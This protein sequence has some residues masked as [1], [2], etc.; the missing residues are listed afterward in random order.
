MKKLMYCRSLKDTSRAHICLCVFVSACDSATP[1]LC[2]V[3]QDIKRALCLERRQRSFSRCIPKSL[4]FKM[5][6]QGHHPMSRELLFPSPEAGRQ[7]NCPADSWGRT[8]SFCPRSL[9]PCQVH[10]TNTSTSCHITL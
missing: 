3:S 1:D 2:Q 5:A 4:S 10:W 7:E 9:W 6:Y 8:T